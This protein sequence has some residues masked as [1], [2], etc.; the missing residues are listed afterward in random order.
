MRARGPA[1]TFEF[2]ACKM[3]AFLKKHDAAPTAA[4]EP[5]SGT[6]IAPSAPCSQTPAP[7]VPACASKAPSLLPTTPMTAP[8][9]PAAAPPPEPEVSSTKPADEVAPEADSSEAKSGEEL[10]TRAEPTKEE[11]AGEVGA[12]EAMLEEAAGEA[13][14]VGEAADAGEVAD[15]GEPANK[16]LGTWL[17][18]RTG[19]RPASQSVFAELSDDEDSA[20]KRPRRARAE[21]DDPWSVDVEHEPSKRALEAQAKFVT[22]AQGMTLLLAPNS[23]SG[24]EGVSHSLKSDITK[25]YEAFGHVDGK[26][27]SLG[28][29]GT[30]LEAAIEY[31]R[32][33]LESHEWRIDPVTV[34]D[35]GYPG[36]IGYV[37]GDFLEEYGE[38]EGQLKWDKAIPTTHEEVRLARMR[39]EA[40]LKEAAEKEAAEKEAETA[41]E[42]TAAAEDPEA[43]AE[44]AMAVEEAATEAEG[45]EAEE[46][47]QLE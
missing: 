4:A 24:Y 23:F 7:A 6:P 11:E 29:F 41:E 35:P 26:K 38:E 44:E 32:N 14:D 3:L 10:P 31:T 15:A 2:P 9:A 25:Q 40:E 42:G 1:P 34:G 16:F 33:V 17:A 39:A 28:S 18:R 12:P 47:G 21:G 22:E 37:I 19:G 43:P 27:R 46:A 5:G 20:P 30:A 8:A 36:G 13:A 45:E